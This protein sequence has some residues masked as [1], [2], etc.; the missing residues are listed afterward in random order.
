[1]N[2]T[3]SKQKKNQKNNTYRNL[4]RFLQFLNVTLH[5]FVQAVQI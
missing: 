3:L 4:Y 5:H 2:F 1:M